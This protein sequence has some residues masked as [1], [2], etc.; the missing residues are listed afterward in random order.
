MSPTDQTI[1]KSFDKTLGTR[2][3]QYRKHRCASGRPT[4][5]SYC[6]CLGTLE[7]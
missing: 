1:S 4:L 3:K 2:P 6:F 5:E 7:V